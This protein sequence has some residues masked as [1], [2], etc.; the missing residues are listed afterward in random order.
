MIAALLNPVNSGGANCSPGVTECGSRVSSPR[1]ARTFSPILID[2]AV[3][4]VD[5]AMAA[6]SHVIEGAE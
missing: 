3:R 5:K 1:L 4:D 2:C 6:V